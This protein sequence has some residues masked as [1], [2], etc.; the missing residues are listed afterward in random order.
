VIANEVADPQRRSPV[1][2]E[3]LHRALVFLSLSPRGE[4]SEITPSPRP[5]VDLARVEPIL[6]GLQF[7]DHSAASGL[8]PLRN[9]GGSLES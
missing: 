2:F 3:I 5:R 1:S 7:S 4:G 9:G 8:T 6:T